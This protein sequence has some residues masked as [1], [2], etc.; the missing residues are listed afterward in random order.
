MIARDLSWQDKKKD[1]GLYAV[2]A[3]AGSPQGVHLRRR[4]AMLCVQERNSWPLI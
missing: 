2:V 1:C 3:L 4:I